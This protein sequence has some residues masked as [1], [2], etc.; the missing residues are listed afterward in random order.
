MPL[1]HIHIYTHPLTPIHISSSKMP[2]LSASILPGTARAGKQKVDSARCADLPK[3]IPSP[4][5]FP[6]RW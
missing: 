6:V 2:F 3:L 4:P 5:G 1:P